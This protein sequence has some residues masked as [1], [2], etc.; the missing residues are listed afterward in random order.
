MPS[1]RKHCEG[2]QPSRQVNTVA[3]SRLIEV[4]PGLNGSIMMDCLNALHDYHN[5]YLLDII[6]F[7][8]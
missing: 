3:L 4:R 7:N 6:E 2:K 8:D 1:A 5:I